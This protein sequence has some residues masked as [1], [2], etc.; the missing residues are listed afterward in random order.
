MDSSHTFFYYLRILK[1]AWKWFKKI[2]TIEFIGKRL[3]RVFHFNFI[4]DFMY[5]LVV[6]TS[7]YYTISKDMT[8]YSKALDMHKRHD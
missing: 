7:Q 3:Y 1:P 8:S 2:K 5:F 4:S 6:H